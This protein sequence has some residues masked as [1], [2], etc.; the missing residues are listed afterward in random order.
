MYRTR[1]CVDVI[2][3]KAWAEICGVRKYFAPGRERAPEHGQVLIKLFIP[4]SRGTLHPRSRIMQSYEKPPGVGVTHPTHTPTP[5][6]MEY[7]KPWP[8]LNYV[9]RRGLGSVNISLE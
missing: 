8:S 3:F 1:A 7:K 4:G 6:N 5:R 9:V 2:V